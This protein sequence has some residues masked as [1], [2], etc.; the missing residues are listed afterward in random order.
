MKKYLLLV[1]TVFCLAGCGTDSPM[2][3]GPDS[4]INEL[5]KTTFLDCFVHHKWVYDHPNV[6]TWEEWNVFD[7][8]V[9]YYSNASSFIYTFS[10]KDVKCRYSIDNGAFLI[11]TE[12]FG[13]V[14]GILSKWDKYEFTWKTVDGN[15]SYSCL[16]ETDT[17]ANGSTFEPT[18]SRL[19]TDAEISCYLSH[20]QTIAD[21]DASGKIIAKNQGRTYIDVV[22]DKG[23]AV[24]EIYVDGIFSTDY[25]AFLNSSQYN[26]VSIH[27]EPTTVDDEK[28]EYL[29]DN[30]NFSR[31]DF[32]LNDRN[33]ISKISLTM[34]AS[35]K[36]FITNNDIIAYLSEN[37]HE[38][39][40]KS[41]FSVK[42]YADNEDPDKAII[43]ASWNKTQKVL[44]FEYVDSKE[45]YISNYESKNGEYSSLLGKSR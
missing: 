17:I 20:N 41:T 31:V 42:Y 12:K 30:G 29:Y 21:V 9:M 44:T 5:Q 33:N 1:L 36:C 25:V 18:Y 13:T 38:Y 40:K 10:N 8:G 34:A 43:L 11:Q 24:V 35:S 27:G 15:F 19:I 4:I 14:E 23:T 28:M 26:V 16:L 39:A 6:P 7:D 22:T 45:K 2:T 32:Y 3:L 37:F